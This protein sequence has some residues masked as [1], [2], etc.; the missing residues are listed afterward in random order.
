[1]TLWEAT[2]RH[3]EQLLSLASVATSQQTWMAG[4]RAHRLIPWGRISRPLSFFFLIP[5]PTS[6]LL[7]SC[8]FQHAIYTSTLRTPYAQRSRMLAFLL[9]FQN[10]STCTES[11]NHTQYSHCFLFWFEPQWCTIT[12]VSIPPTFVRRMR[13]KRLPLQQSHCLFVCFFTWHLTSWQRCRV[14]KQRAGVH[15]ADLWGR[16]WP[17][18]NQRKEEHACI[19][20]CSLCTSLD[21]HL[22]FK[23]NWN[24]KYLHV[25]Y[26]YAL[27]PY[28]PPPLLFFCK[29]CS[30]CKT[31]H[32]VHF[33]RSST[34]RL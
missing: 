5:S 25:V 23:S 30:C 7:L 19:H 3:W 31:M 27:C 8:E 2:S 13:E 28:Y 33:Q 34:E 4:R 32:W 12:S 29:C 21:N 26:K 17:L 18:P 10:T 11:Y 16:I 14:P 22:S 6:P 1:M 15:V 9:L 24:V 20:T